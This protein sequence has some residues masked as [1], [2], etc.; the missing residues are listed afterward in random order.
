MSQ[1]HPV[2]SESKEGHKNNMEAYLKSMIANLKVNPTAKAGTSL[3]I[4]QIKSNTL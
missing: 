2:V 3:A 1:Q 4:N